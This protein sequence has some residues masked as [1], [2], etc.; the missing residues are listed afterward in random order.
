MAV[1][2]QNTE[3][4]LSGVSRVLIADDEPDV[5]AVTKLTLKG[6]AR[7]YGPMEFVSAHSG[8]ET[9]AALRRD[10]G[11]G[12]V[13]LDVVMETD[14]AGLEVSRAIRSDLG[15]PL[16]RILLRTGQPGIAPEQ[17]TI[18]AYDIDGYL[19]KTETS[20]S[21][22]YTAVRCALKSYQ[23][24]VALE[25]HRTYLAGAHDCAVS[26]QATMPVEQ[27]LRRVLDAVLT[28]C[29]A[30]LVLLELETFGQAAGPRRLFLYLASDPTASRAEVAA[31]NTR[32]R[33]RAGAHAA[34]ASGP[35]ELDG[36]FYM[37]LRLHHELG[38]GWIFVDRFAPDE[39]KRQTLM[40]LAAHAQNAIYASIALAALRERRSLVF[41]EAAI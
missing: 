14:H 6:L 34:E 38:H 31:E 2:R 3:L 32:V 7:K 41:Q 22:L 30:P 5:H 40:V 4:E 39:A 35:C 23:Q 19:A 20:A 10:P 24:L 26:L 12:V 17:Q 8:A 33:V 25:R 37:P 21:R 9:I 36:G 27:M 13:L 18:D 16:V 1:V 28:L 11:I 29:P 15:N